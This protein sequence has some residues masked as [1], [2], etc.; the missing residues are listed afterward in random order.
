MKCESLSATLLVQA[1][2]I[3]WG[4][5]GRSAAQCITPE[6]IKQDEQVVAALYAPV[7]IQIETTD[8]DTRLGNHWSHSTN[9][10]ALLLSSSHLRQK[11]RYWRHGDID[12]HSLTVVSRTKFASQ[13]STRSAKGSILSKHHQVRVPSKSLPHFARDDETK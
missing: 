6:G 12:F 13:Y 11:S 7:T 2:W 10:R 8:S 3:I 5:T 1:G 4:W 9:R